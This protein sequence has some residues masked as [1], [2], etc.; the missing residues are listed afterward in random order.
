MLGAPPFWH[1][2]GTRAKGI[3]IGERLAVFIIP[4]TSTTRGR[5]DTRAHPKRWPSRLIASA[6][7]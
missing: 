4:V 7:M 6:S 1:H 2:D 5:A 3:R